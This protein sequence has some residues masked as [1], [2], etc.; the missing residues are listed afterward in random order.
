LK[1]QLALLTALVLSVS[2]AQPQPET[3]PIP[4]PINP[5][6]SPKTTP[7]KV[8]PILPKV[9]PEIPGSIQ[10]R[11]PGQ[12]SPQSLSRIP[13]NPSMPE[14]AKIEY[15]SNGFIEVAHAL[16]LIPKKDATLENDLTFAFSAVQRSFSLR[17]ALEEVDFS[18]FE[19]EGYAG[20][21][22]PLPR[23]TG[24][25]TRK[26]LPR[27]LQLTPK[28]LSGFERIWSNGGISQKPLR[29]ATTEKEIAPTYSGDKGSLQAQ[30]I[31]QEKSTS[32][33][34]GGLLFQGSP[35]EPVI[36]LTF[37]DA[38][39]PLYEPLLLDI[40]RRTH[41][42]ATFFC[43]GRNAEAYPYFVRDMVRQ[44]H[45]IGNHT[46][47]HVRLIG[48]SPAAVT[49]ELE[50]TSKILSG[51]TGTTPKFFRPP[52][53]RYSSQT[54]QLAFKAGLT[55]TFWTDDPGDFRNAGERMLERRLVRRLRYGGIV[56]LHDNVLDSIQVLPQ[57]L[58][59]AFLRGIHVDNV[60]GL[61]D[62]I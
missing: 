24:S 9:Q 52:G 51:I 10:P 25:I 20:A 55:T 27:F 16:I 43:I 18:V 1:F 44:G 37:D 32:G 36:A 29:Q 22:G 8:P 4:L 58:K 50:R 40:L 33:V 21:G 26:L 53:G 61:L 45:E 42:R 30:Q 15:A 17:P 13:T 19:K 41:V 28:T 5:P 12:R 57:F 7:K 2:L 60:T 3:Q 14:I 38:P 23:L 59:V 54:L 39:H 31:E 34:T 56:L 48:L 49:D 6:V 62:A 11:A 46:Y 35:E 47:H